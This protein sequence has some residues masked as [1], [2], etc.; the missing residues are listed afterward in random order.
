MKKL[1]IIICSLLFITL[2]ALVVTAAFSPTPD[3]PVSADL[4]PTFDLAAE[5]AAVLMF[6]AAPAPA[7]APT[8]VAAHDFSMLMALGLFFSPASLWQRSLRKLSLLNQRSISNASVND[9]GTAGPSFGGPLK[10]PL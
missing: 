8:P 2:I 7:P 5:G 9:D 4:M 1:R 3:T 10:F 6:D